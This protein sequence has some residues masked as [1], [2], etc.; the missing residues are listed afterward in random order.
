M[1]TRNVT[2]VKAGNRIKVAQ[3]GQWDGYPTGQGFT[4]LDFLARADLKIFRKK[5]DNV[6]FMK[7]W[8]LKEY[9]NKAGADKDGMISMSDSDRAK[10]LHPELS[11]DTGAKILDLIYDY[12]PNCPPE[13]LVVNKMGLH[14]QRSFLNDGMYCEWA[15]ELDLTKH[16]LKVFKDGNHVIATYPLDAPPSKKDFKKLEKKFVNED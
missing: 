10:E 11:R 13:D 14:D 4:I 5:L 8:E 2:L 1:G 6:R 7:E 9:W 16:T 12:D 15:Y 3:Y